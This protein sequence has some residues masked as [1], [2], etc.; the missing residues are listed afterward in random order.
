VAEKF[1]LRDSWHT[2]GLLKCNL[3]A[4]EK[5][6]FKALTHLYQHVCG[7][8]REE[9]TLKYDGWSRCN[10]QAYDKAK[11][12]ALDSGV[13]DFS[14]FEIER[15]MMDMLVSVGAGTGAG[16]LGYKMAE[17]IRTEYT[18]N[19]NNGIELGVGLC[20]GLLGFLGTLNYMGKPKK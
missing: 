15:E 19:N 12:G 3:K 14:K 5:I 10:L 16:F 9:G 7:H 2:H 13:I 18:D 6:R 20:L 17:F 11:G 4:D 1:E 8:K